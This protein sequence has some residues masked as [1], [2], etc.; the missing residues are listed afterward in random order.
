MLPMKSCGIGVIC[1]G[2][3]QSQ[4]HDPG[5]VFRKFNVEAFSNITQQY[6]SPPTAA[7]V[8]SSLFSLLRRRAIER[9]ADASARTNSQAATSATPASEIHISTS[10]AVGLLLLVNALP[11]P[12]RA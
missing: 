12:A 2:L 8:I 3:A 9:L 4:K 10:A 6:Y 1:G 11:K 5:Q 7:P